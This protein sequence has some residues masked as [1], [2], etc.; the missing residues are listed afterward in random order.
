MK[1]VNIVSSFTFENV[2]QSVLLSDVESVI[3]DG[4]LI[5][6]VLVYTPRTSDDD[7]CGS[8]SFA[9]VTKYDKSDKVVEAEELPNSPY[10]NID[11]GKAL[12][13]I[14]GAMN[15]LN[16]RDTKLDKYGKLFKKK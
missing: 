11:D 7:Y 6:V 15:K 1:T 12:N 4:K 9:K 14:K 16:Y 13:K 2:H 8:I 5:D 3:I 10:L